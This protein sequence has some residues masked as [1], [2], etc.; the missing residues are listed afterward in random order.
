MDLNFTDRKEDKDLDQLIMDDQLDK[1]YQAYNNYKKERSMDDNID[2]KDFMDKYFAQ[3]NCDHLHYDIA[4]S[5]IMQISRDFEAFEQKEL[6]PTNK[7]PIEFNN[8]ID[9]LG[10]NVDEFEKMV[11][12]MD[13]GTSQYTSSNVHPS[14]NPLGC[15]SSNVNVACYEG[16]CI[17]RGGDQ[18]IS[19]M[20]SGSSST[21]MQISKDF[22][23]FERTKLTP[24]TETSIDL[25]DYID[26]LGEDVYETERMVEE[27]ASQY[28]SSDPHPHPFY[29]NAFG[30]YNN[31]V[32]IA[33]DSSGPVIRYFYCGQKARRKRQKRK[34]RGVVMSEE[35]RLQQMAKQKIRN[36]EVAARTHEMRLAREAYLES[37]HLELLMEN[38]FLKKTV[39]FLEDHKRVNVPPEPLRRTISGP[40]L[41]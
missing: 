37:Q 38:D 6:P 26:Q 13:S 25:N 3:N 23:A 12:E 4:E 1:L 10:E 21:V 40:I 35:H 7:T 5:S 20:A 28:T 24:T 31:V 36:R 29:N 2:P 34:Y 33:N 27:M 39:K 16:D 8:N 19:G 22:E 11:E 17:T 14:Y 15:Y 41:I 32:S 9:Q 18:F 30:C